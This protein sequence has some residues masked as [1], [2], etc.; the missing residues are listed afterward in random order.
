MNEG[1]INF[2]DLSGVVCVDVEH[3]FSIPPNHTTRITI[4]EK[5]DGSGRFYI[6]A[7]DLIVMGDRAQWILTPGSARAADNP[8][9]A[10]KHADDLIRREIGEPPIVERKVRQVRKR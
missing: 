2:G 9:D 3:H 1:P 8:T 6:G 10:A 4:T 5:R 7:E